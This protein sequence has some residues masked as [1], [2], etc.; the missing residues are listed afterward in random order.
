MGRAQSPVDG[1]VRVDRDLRRRLSDEVDELGSVVVLGP[2]L[3]RQL[4]VAPPPD[5]EFRRLRPEHL[6]FGAVGRDEDGLDD[7]FGPEIVDLLRD[8]EL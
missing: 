5:P 8:V 1:V 7:R 4:V 2:V 6:H 3:G